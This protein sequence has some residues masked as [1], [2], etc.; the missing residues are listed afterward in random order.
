MNR[1][2]LSLVLPILLSILIVLAGIIFTRNRTASIRNEKQNELTAIAHLI[3]SQ[4]SEWYV[5]ELYDA[6]VI[7]Q[8]YLLIEK[9]DLWL[10]NKEQGTK[11]ILHYYITTLKNEH[12]YKD[13]I[14][15]TPEGKI[16]MT[17]EDT[18]PPSDSIL[19]RSIREAVKT[20]SVITTDLYRSSIDK[21]IYID[22]LSPVLSEDKKPF[23]IAIFRQDP[24]Q[25][26]YPLIQSW[27]YPSKTSESLLIEQFNDSV[28]YLNELRHLKNTALK[29]KMP[30]TQDDL[31]SV[32]ALSGYTGIFYGKDYRGIAVMAYLSPIPNTPWYMAVKV[33]KSEL[34]A[35]IYKE[36]GLV[37]I[38]FLLLILLLALG[39]AL[40]SST[41]QRNIYHTL[42][43]TQEE[44]RA[45]LYSIGDGVITT[46]EEGLV[47]H[48]NPVAEQLTGW[49]EKEAKGKSLENLLQLINESTH[50][51]IDNP[52]QK[53]LHKRQI[54]GLTNHILLI[55]RDGKN[56]PVSL[57]GAP[58]KERNGLLK[59]VVL[60][61]RDQT[62]E[63]EKQ[64]L[65]EENENRFTA[66]MNYLPALVLIKDNELRPIYANLHY[67]KLFPIESWMGKKPE[68]T[69]PPEV[70]GPMI[71]NDHLALKEG[72][73]NYEEK[74]KDKNGIEHIYDT[75]KFRID[76]GE[77]EP[78][79][80]AII[81][82]ITSRKQ[83]ESA[84]ARETQLLE[85][86][87]T[88][89]PDNIYFKDAQSRFIGINNSLVK[90]FGL[91]SSNEA[92]GK[93]DFDF[94]DRKHAEE[95]YLDEQQIISSGVPIVNKEEREVRPNGSIRWVSTTKVPLK[96][97]L[98]KIIGI[99]G[100]S[101][102]I[103]ES[104]AVENDLRIR[105]ERYKLVS[106]LTSDY[107]YKIDIDEQSQLSLNFV[108]ESFLGITG[109]Q[110]S[111][112]STME[113]WN[114]IFHPDDLGLMKKFVYDLITSKK[115]GELECRTFVKDN[116]SRWVHILSKP[117]LD[118]EGN[119]VISIIGSVKDI[120]QR[121]K[122]EKAL[123]ESEE[124]F[125]NF[126]EYSPVYVF[127]KDENIRAIKL[128]KNYEQMLGIPMNEIL[129]KTMN[130]I[131]P[132]ELAKNMIEDDKRILNEGKFVVVDEEFNGRFFTTIKYP[133]QVDE[134]TRY[135]AGFTIDITDRKKAEEAL[136][137]QTAEIEKQNEEYLSLNKIYEIVNEE[138]RKSNEELSS[139]RDKAEESDQ[140]KSAFL[141]NMSHEIR[142][143][144][145]AI[146]GFSDLLND[147][148]L[149]KE[150][151]KQY[152][153]TIKQRSYD[154]LTLINDILDISKIEA[155]QL[156]LAE[157]SGNLE[158]LI[159][160]VFNTFKIIWCDSGKSPVNLRYSYGLSVEEGNVI[161]DRG[162]VRQILTNLVGNAFK[163][164][165]EGSIT[166]GCQ[167]KD[168]NSLLF[169]VTDTG[170]GISPDKQ[171]IIFDRFRQADEV[172]SQQYGGTG[173][174]L[175]IS[176]G[177][178]E[179]LGGSIWVESEPGK[180]STFYFTVPYRP[181]IKKPEPRPEI[182]T[183]SHR[184]KNKKILLI[185]DDEYNTEYLIEALR[186]TGM[187]II[188]VGNG[189]E[190]IELIKKGSTFDLM[191]LDI[192]LPDIDGFEVAR[193]IKLHQPNLPIIAQTAYASESYKIRCLEAG[194]SDYIVKP[195]HQ[196]D[197]IDMIGHCLK[198]N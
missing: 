32:K 77:K 72:Y 148:G 98:G 136:M 60:I 5:D 61:I 105:E 173:L 86:L 140:L 59:G 51:K 63:R 129:G 157:E 39:F 2:W 174:G 196:T 176:K 90:I 175:S 123:Q 89:I 119:R 70:S 139:A 56:I 33:D 183:T 6:K 103:T 99:M 178:V 83:A 121:K 74:W 64:R 154:L 54:I 102:D 155:G 23:A 37:L 7:S 22:F 20:K 195:I 95:A 132:S 190:G 152:T 4:I 11:N 104:K 113:S 115:E 40:S 159:T 84:L 141:A 26:L 167:M 163:F 76:R 172:N 144:M 125:R 66:F 168:K 17:A 133:I 25:F 187:Q 142:T 75:H 19:A 58:I 46:N 38:M 134:H 116:Q 179:L 191:L 1:K 198:K 14:L 146:I 181:D 62:S 156:I 3:I 169:Y 194:C 9:I 65:I 188:Q 108:S 137:K 153:H 15:A 164:T 149:P 170:I 96:D 68:E 160:D 138:L 112:V 161:T 147:P 182:K 82:D 85:S 110:L 165:K 52:V 18:I 50:E 162:R 29:F 184:W 185:E 43:Q 171:T 28:L 16:L 126:L 117:I 78:Y 186:E 21:Q 151:L 12:G 158:E 189:Q 27:P 192:R 131:F 44:F 73:L 145:N 180:G 31:P 13:I 88:T 36:N 24:D 106:E 109:R 118:K 193:Q 127:F 53:I 107:I 101:R 10:R 114:G 100:I 57:S 45:T 48:L 91:K 135:L 81:L 177:L 130:E 47:L 8:N 111:Q 122:A 143:P 35:N 67:Q 166:L 42:L 150:K 69:F 120:T 41:R 55:A 34:F 97:E 79:L 49:K 71:E 87:I 197:L 93:T 128:S 30:L 80:G 124:I 92:Y 94:F